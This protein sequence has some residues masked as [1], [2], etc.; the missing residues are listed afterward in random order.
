MKSD[1]RKSLQNIARHDHDP[2]KGFGWEVIVS[3]RGLYHR[4]YFSDSHHG[5][6]AGALTAA[7]LYRDELLAWLPR[8]LPVKTR[9]TRNTSGAV[10]VCVAA[11]PRKGWTATYVVAH[12]PGEG[13]A[14]FS[15]DKLGF[16]EAW[17]RAIAAR[18][19]ALAALGVTKLPAFPPKRQTRRKSA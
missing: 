19:K 4:E 17:R 18:K 2:L 6:K 9:N 8:R 11:K 3:R 7:Q 1:R 12:W 5:G 15:A 16:K 13:T 10:G 14:S